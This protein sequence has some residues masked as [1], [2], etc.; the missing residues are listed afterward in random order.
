MNFGHDNHHDVRIVAGGGDAVVIVDGTHVESHIG[1]YSLE[2]HVGESSPLL[3]LYQNATEQAAFEGMARV[4][5]TD[6]QDESSRLDAFVRGIDYGLL[7]SAA[8]QRVN[9]GQ[10]SGSTARAIVEQFVDWY[11]GR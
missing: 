2:Q 10:G 1:G 3:T 5:V 7:E 8:L 4:Q 6:T 9:P 11:L